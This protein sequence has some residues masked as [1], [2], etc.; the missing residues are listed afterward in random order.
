MTDTQKELQ[1]Q[2]KKIQLLGNATG[3]AEFDENGNAT[4]TVIVN[5][6]L[7]AANADTCTS[8]NYATNSGSAITA[9]SAGTAA[10]CTGNSATATKAEQDG[11]GNNIATTYATKEEVN[12]LAEKIPAFSFTMTGGVLTISNGNK[13]YQFIGTAV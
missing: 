8:T 2:P 7:T 11:A 10:N 9:L 4:V 12:K 5:R 13:T 6:A 1:V 3:S